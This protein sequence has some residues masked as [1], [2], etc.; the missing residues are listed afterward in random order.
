MAVSMSA[1]LESLLSLCEEFGASDLHVSAGIAPRFRI[2]GA[3]VEKGSFRPFD[4]KTVDALAMELGLFTLPAG[5]PDGTESVRMALMR[6]GSLDGAFEGPSG[7]RY[8]FNVYRESDRHAIA[9][10]RLDSEFRSFEELGLPLRLA[11]FCNETDGL[12]IVTG[13]TG[14]G[15]STTL[16]TMLDT[17]NRSRAGHIVTIEDPVEFVHVPGMCMVSQR[18]VGRDVRS[19]DDAIVEAMRQD[20]DVI[21]V[22]E[23]RDLA[24]VRAALRAAETGHL[25]FTTL[26]AGDCAGAL[27]RLIS[28]FP[29]E[30]QNSARHQLALVLRGVFAQHL[31]T[32]PDGLRRPVCE[33]LVNTPACANVIATGRSAQ[34]YSIIETGAPQ[35]MRTLDQSLAELLSA[36]LVD[37]RTAYALSKNPDTLKGRLRL[38]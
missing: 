4:M 32:S 13:P 33:L 30:E 12:V 35:G 11:D 23:T 22:G 10:R 24:T 1:M 2:R 6:E 9:V 37:E 21:L 19:F 31:V 7:A 8:R 16:A 5:C 38:C 15:K 27:E 17:I 14:S 28:V 34:I 25:V 36:G 29:P 3:L 20:P 18:Q 26:H